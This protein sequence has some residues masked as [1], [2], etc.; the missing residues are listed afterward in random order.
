MSGY[1]EILSTRPLNDELISIASDKKVNLHIVPFIKTEPVE[2]V[3]VQQELE[4]VFL[5]NTTVVFTSMNAVESVFEYY[6]NEHLQWDIYCIGFATKELVEKYFGD[7]LIAGIA[8]NAAELAELIID[9]GGIEEVTFFCGDRHRRE[10]P[11]ML[12]ENG[13]TVN[14]VIVY[15]TVFIPRRI[16]KEYDGILFFSPSAVESFFSVNELPA[17]TIVFAI[18]ST[19]AATVEQFCDN[20]LI[21]SSSPSKDHMVREAVHYFTS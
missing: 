20:K 9:S 1:I 14:E 15:Q 6:S 16:L 8:D 18:G 7:H 17:K 4:Q 11:E 10:L 19:T 2:S 3:E 5:M 21:I 12:A 13:I